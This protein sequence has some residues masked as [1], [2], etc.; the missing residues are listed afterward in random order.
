MVKTMPIRSNKSIPKP[1]PNS[2]HPTPSRYPL[3]ALINYVFLQIKKEQAL[4]NA[5]P[6][7]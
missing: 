5:Y 6:K 7:K 1:I 4:A 3:K 2:I